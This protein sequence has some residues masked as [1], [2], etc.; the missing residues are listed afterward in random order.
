M[1]RGRMHGITRV[2]HLTPRSKTME[3]RGLVMKKFYTSM[4]LLSASVTV[5]S[6]GCDPRK[7]VTTEGVSSSPVQ[8]E[9]EA[10]AA[11]GASAL[12]RAR[13]AASPIKV[14][15]FADSKRWHDGKAEVA[16]YRGTRMRYGKAREFELTL[17]Q[18]KEPFDARLLVKSDAPGGKETIP[19]MKTQVVYTMPTENYPYQF[20][21]STFSRRDNPF[22]LVKSVTTSHE[23]CGITTKYLDL[24]G[25]KPTWRYHSYF[26]DE[27]Q[28]DLEL[29]WPTRGVFEEQLFLAVRALPLEVG[30]REELQVFSGQINSHARTPTWRK[31]MLEV[32]D[33]REVE[34]ATGASHEVWHIEVRFE[35]GSAPLIYDVGT[36]EERT[37]VHHAGTDGFELRLAKRVR[38]AY[39]SFGEPSPFGGE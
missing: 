2:V 39:W 13:A 36:D 21:S 6:L 29:T 30:L 25:D 5:A 24:R 8:V 22:A 26:E 19:V 20:A 32:V 33:R 17:V 14:T 1:S 11:G 3:T 12:E 16:K 35:D 38:W 37:L 9:E 23:W 34:D 31:G 28:G 10:D 15:N 7:Q 27:S 4:L 18:V